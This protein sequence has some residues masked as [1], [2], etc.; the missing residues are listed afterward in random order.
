MPDVSE[1]G[2][3]TDPTRGFELRN[4]LLDHSGSACVNSGQS[5]HALKVRPEPLLAVP[6]DHYM[7]LGLN[8]GSQTGHLWGSNSDKY[9]IY[10]HIIPPRKLNYT[11]Q[12]RM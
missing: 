3:E 7:V 4:L 5:L 10:T 2:L 11:H 8:Y 12:A 9:Q 6:Q 1:D